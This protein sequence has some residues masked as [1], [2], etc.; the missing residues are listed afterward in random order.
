MLS[1]KLNI[2]YILVT[3]GS[4]GMMLVGKDNITKHI[5]ATSSKEVFDVTG[6]GDTVI[7]VLCAA[8]VSSE[9][10]NDIY[11][12]AYSCKYCSWRSDKK[13]RCSICGRK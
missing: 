3:M 1:K 7:A 4:D 8:F 13:I 11:F 5:K 12:A 2:N 6:A 9:N 10:D